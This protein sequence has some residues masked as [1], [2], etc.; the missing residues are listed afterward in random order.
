MLSTGLWRWY[1][2]ITITILDII[3]RPVFYLKQ[4]PVSR[5]SWTNERRNFVIINYVCNSTEVN[6]KVQ[7]S[8]WTVVE[9]DVPR[10]HLPP[11]ALSGV[12]RV[13]E[14]PVNYRTTTFKG[15]VPTC[16]ERTAI[17]ACNIVFQLPVALSCLLSHSLTHLHFHSL[18]ILEHVSVHPAGFR[19]LSC[20]W[21]CHAVFV[22]SKHISKHSVASFTHRTN[23]VWAALFYSVLSLRCSRI[24]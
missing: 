15:A 13:H 6:T 9:H 22:Y 23:L 5:T 3:H 17:A 24:L 14:A 16:I 8:V 18:Y 11:V 1:I 21:H 19:Q 4:N 7:E 12:V 20:S 2:N 10:E